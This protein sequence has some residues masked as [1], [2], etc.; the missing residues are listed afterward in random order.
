MREE[1]RRK[2][3]GIKFVL[4]LVFLEHHMLECTCALYLKE[5]VRETVPE[6]REGK[7]GVRGW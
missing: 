3:I 4:F 6:E 7:R 2:K 1:K 5:K